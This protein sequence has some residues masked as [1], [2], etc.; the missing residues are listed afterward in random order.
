MV[1]CGESV[2]L[3]AAEHATRKINAT[4]GKFRMSFMEYWWGG[5]SA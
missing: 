2:W 1:G 4:S 3:V 5:M